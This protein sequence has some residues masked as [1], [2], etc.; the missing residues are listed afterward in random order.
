MCNLHMVHSTLDNCFIV[1]KSSMTKV[2]PGVIL[3]LSVETAY[4]IFPTD[5]EVEIILTRFRDGSSLHVIT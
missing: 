4:F 5:K 3:E 2:D 1:S